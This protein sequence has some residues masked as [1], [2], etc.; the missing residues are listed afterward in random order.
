MFNQGVMRVQDM[1]KENGNKE[2]EFDVSKLTVFCVDVYSNEVDEATTQKT[3]QKILDLIKEN[4]Y[5][6]TVELAEACNLTRDGVTYQIRKLKKNGSIV[7]IGPDI[8]HSRLSCRK[9]GV[10]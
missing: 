8:I 2:A 4:P 6:S 9:A 10:T 7:R 1:L 5:I 3:T